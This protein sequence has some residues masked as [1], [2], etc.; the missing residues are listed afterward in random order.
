MA[1][2]EVQPI[3][4]HEKLHGLMSSH[5]DVLISFVELMYPHNQSM[6][7][8]FCDIAASQAFIGIE[9]VEVNLSKADQTLQELAKATGFASGHPL[10]V[11]LHGNQ[12]IDSL[13]GHVCESEFKSWIAQ[14]MSSALNANQK[15][16]IIT[17]SS[18]GHHSHH[19]KHA[20]FFYKALS[21]LHL[22]NGHSASKEDLSPTGS[23]SEESTYSSQSSTIS[24]NYSGSLPSYEAANESVGLNGWPGSRT[25]VKVDISVIDDAKKN[26]AQPMRAYSSSITRSD[27]PSRIHHRRGNGDHLDRPGRHMSGLWGR[28]KHIDD[29]APG[30]AVP[31][32]KWHHVAKVSIGSSSFDIMCFNAGNTIRFRVS[33]IPDTVKSTRIS[34]AMFHVRFG[35]VEDPTISAMAPRDYHGQ[36]TTV[37]IATSVEVQGGGA[38]GSH[39]AALTAGV[40]RKTQRAWD[41]ETSSAVKGWGL[42]SSAADWTFAEDKVG[43]GLDAVYDLSVDLQGSPTTMTFWASAKLETRLPIWELMEIGSSRKPYFRSLVP[44]PPQ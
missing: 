29:P 14:C 16:H 34:A 40:D 31:C 4:C 12:H 15:A 28:A 7:T 10:A 17:L 23:A 33:F 19:H 32:S 20:G 30:E 9:F 35:G 24:S 41:E 8:I 36:V 44:Q 5:K 22:H 13:P 43:H 27:S 1:L 25:R 37:H 6:Q 18:H 3:L 26:E 39:G 21:H 11:F 2:L 42:N 38:V